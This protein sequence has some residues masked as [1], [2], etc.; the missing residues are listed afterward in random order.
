M[1]IIEVANF[2]SYVVEANS[3][4]EA[5]ELFELQWFKLNCDYSIKHANG[6]LINKD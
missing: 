2:G 1:F 5:I 6:F 3:N 4:K